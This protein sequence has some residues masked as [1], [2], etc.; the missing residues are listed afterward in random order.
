MI[1]PNTKSAL[2][3]NAIKMA[4][5]DGTLQIGEWINVRAWAAEL[6]ISDTPIKYALMALQAEGLVE[7][8]A[9]QGFLVPDLNEV[10]L[11]DLFDIR[12]DLYLM[13][14]R[15][16]H[17]RRD[18]GDRVLKSPGLADIQF[19]FERL[20]VEIALSSG[21]SALA[22]QIERINMR[23]RLIHRFKVDLLPDLEDEYLRMTRTWRRGDLDALEA[24]IVEYTRRRQDV[25]PEIIARAHEHRR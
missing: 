20:F 22:G 10:S 7:A 11:R 3:Y 15:R 6:K 2:A 8:H 23:L 9:R 24:E 21:R 14:I 16:A 13:A 4:I 17:P 5:L 25:V 19:A 1:E 18:D 12:S